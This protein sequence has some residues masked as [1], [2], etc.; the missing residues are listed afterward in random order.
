MARTHAAP[1]VPPMAAR[2]SDAE[3]IDVQFDAEPIEAEPIETETVTVV[4]TTAELLGRAKPKRP[5]ARAASNFVA[6]APHGAS[7]RGSKT[8]AKKTAGTRRRTKKESDSQ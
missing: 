8:G 1:T 5:R 2:V 3:T 4:D 6:A 7:R